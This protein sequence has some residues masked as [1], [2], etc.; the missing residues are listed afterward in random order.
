MALLRKMVKMVHNY[1]VTHAVNSTAHPTARLHDSM[2]LANATLEASD[3]AN[4][5]DDTIERVEYQLNVARWLEYRGHALAPDE[6][7]E[8]KEAY[9]DEVPWQDFAQRVMNTRTLVTLNTEL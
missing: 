3:W 7:A 6:M 8:M 4:G 2:A 9:D 5:L 1:S